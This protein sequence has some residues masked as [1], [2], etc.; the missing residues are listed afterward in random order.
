MSDE[1]WNN[2]YCDS[3]YE[4]GLD[5]SPPGKLALEIALERGYSNALDIGCGYGR[6]VLY[7]ALGGIKTTGIDS[8][9]TGIGMAR[10]LAGERGINAHFIQGDVVAYP[11]V[12]ES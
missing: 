12:A 5:P 9:G 8:S 1:Y 4:W 11:F 6:D 2:K 3:N 10:E 7:L